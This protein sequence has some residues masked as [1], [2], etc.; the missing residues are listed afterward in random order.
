MIK[1]VSV[2]IPY[3]VDRGYLDKAIDSVKKQTYP[4]IELIISKGDKGVSANLNDGVRKATGDY[5]TYLCDDDLL[6]E[7]SV[8]DQVKCMEQSGAD[9]MHGRAWTLWRDGKMEVKAPD[10]QYPTLDEMIERNRIHGGTLMYKADVFT[11][12]GLFDE[13][14]TTGEE[15]EY[16]LRLLSRGAKIA[17]CNDILYI[18]RRHDAQKSLGKGVDQKAR[19][20]IIQG[21]KDRFTKAKVIVGMATM[22][23]REKYLDMAVNSLQ[24]QVD[25]IIIYDNK[26]KPGLTDNGKF[27]G[28]TEFSEPV[29]YLSCDDDLIYPP[30]YASDMVQAIRRTGTI[31]THH[32]RKLSGLGKDYYHDHECF[33]CLTSN[34]IEQ[35]IDVAGTGV[36]GFYTGYFNPVGIHKTKDKRMSDLIFS[37]E[38]A[39]QN[40]I[41]TLLKRPFGY[42]KEAGVP[43]FQTIAGQDSG[44][45]TRQIE[46]A[47]EIIKTKAG[48]N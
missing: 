1:K 48:R 22:A 13:S 40:K 32:G 39:K 19:Q 41:I 38:A 21:I 16:S 35:T 10:I 36:T 26:D 24:R 12:F 3:R 30:N 45:A 15:Y 20:V 8:S 17:H 37:L 23:G 6:T 31:V 47:D 14:L 44:K 46:I 29:Y 25:E 4:N 42:I 18:Y 2:I 43:Y 11:R 33:R 5:I 34:N 9:F 28:L 27:Y 7:T